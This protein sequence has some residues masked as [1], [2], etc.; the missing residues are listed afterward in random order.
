MARNELLNLAYH[1][2][3]DAMVFIDDDEMWNEK[4]LIDILLSNKDVITVP[5]VN[6]GD[7]NISYN[8]FL[9]ENPEIDSSDGYI[10]VKKTGTG[11]LKL[12]KK[13]I[14]DLWESNPEIFFRNK[15]LKNICE[16][17]VLVDNFIGEDITLSRKIIELGYTIWINPH[18][19][20]SHIG[21]KM[22][23][24]NFLSDM[25]NKLQ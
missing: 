20:V 10:K 1:Q 11:F 4:I 5:V 18:Y 16:Y 22:Y 15:P 17:G 14:I 3:Y 6:K 24:G 13:V 23:K 21:N 19:T 12:S 9:P 8:V 2:N 25:K 7:K